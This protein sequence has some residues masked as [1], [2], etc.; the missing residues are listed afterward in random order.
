[1]QAFHD[2]GLVMDDIIDELNVEPHEQRIAIE[3]SQNEEETRKLL[4]ILQ[5][6]L[7][8]LPQRALEES[9]KL[10]GVTGRDTVGEWLFAFD[11]FIASIAVRFEYIMNE[12][13]SGEAG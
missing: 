2:F 12:W 10:P 3:V 8:T 5:D 7:A 9:V 11:S 1:M 13:E 6:M 4:S